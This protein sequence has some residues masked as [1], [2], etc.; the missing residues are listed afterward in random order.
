[1][2]VVITGAAGF[3]GR[4]LRA[5]LAD[6]ES[7]GMRLTLIDPAAAPAM[8]GDTWLT[9]SDRDAAERSRS[10][11]AADIVVHLAA[12]P[13]GAA[14]RDY[15]ASK[16]VNLDLSLELLG[17]LAGR[18]RPARFVFAST[19]AVF[20]APL[21][22]N[23][24]DDTLPRPS[25]TYGA[26]KLMVETALANLT[27]LGRLSGYALRLPGLV[28]RPAGAGGLT[29]AFLSDLLHACAAR[30]PIAIPTTP[31]ATVWLMSVTCAARN[32]R[33]AMRL[34]DPAPGTPRAIT[35]PALRVSMAEYARVAARVTGADPSLVTFEPDAGLE[36][37]FGRLPPL[38]AP[39]AERLGFRHDG[40]LEALVREALVAAGY[41]RGGHA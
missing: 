37:Q 36:A 19:I 41:A 2:H 9:D 24:D 4:A 26:H 11:D 31:D 6:G 20:G 29:S 30:R 25:M 22:A 14:E 23:V 34:A 27:R 39:L 38:A 5:Q 12:V 21:P 15:A 7:A 17:H 10:L 16:R 8:D 28:A 1:M 35:L 18:A 13:G 40:T 32:I 3:L 33:H